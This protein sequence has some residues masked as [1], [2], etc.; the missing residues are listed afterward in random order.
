MLLNMIKNSILDFLFAIL[1]YMWGGLRKKQSIISFLKHL[2][3][4]QKETICINFQFHNPKLSQEGVLN[5]MSTIQCYVQGALQKKEQVTSFAE[6]F[7]ENH[8]N[9]ISVC[10]ESYIPKL[11]W[12]RCFILSIP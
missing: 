11:I 9:I 5:G 7:K 4:N 1:A 12:E 8:K 10:F 6:H 3:K 2:K